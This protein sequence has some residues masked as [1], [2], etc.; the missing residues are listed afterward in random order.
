MLVIRP[1]YYSKSK[2][3]K[4]KRKLHPIPIF[5]FMLH[6]YNKKVLTKRAKIK[7]MRKKKRK[8]K[9]QRVPFK[10]W[11][12]W[13]NIK[14]LN[15]RLFSNF[16]SKQ[17]KIAIPLI[18]KKNSSRKYYKNVVFLTN[19]YIN[20]GYDY[21]VSSSRYWFKIPKASIYNHFIITYIPINKIKF[22]SIKKS[23]ILKQFQHQNLQYA[24]NRLLRKRLRRWTNRYRK[25]KK[26]AAYNSIVLRLFSILTGLSL[27]HI[28]K[29]WLITRRS[30]LNS[31]GINQLINN[32]TIQ[33]TL[34][35]HN[36][37]FLLRL[38]PSTISGLLLLKQGAIICNGQIHTGSTALQPGDILQLQPN[39]LQSNKF[40]H[41]VT[42]KYS[43]VAYL[44]FIYFDFSLL[45]IMILR[46]PFSY[47]LL[48]HSFLSTRWVR[49]Y[50]RGF[51]IKNKHY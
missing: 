4:R 14:K 36:L 48:F 34:L 32:F 38:I 35:P 28:K 15:Y 50:I 37:L 3:I 27:V 33:I 1:K 31:W 7:L 29:L 9:T 20:S 5:G 17:R 11:R 49:Y 47:E 39:T 19:L 26:H 46:Y 8:F 16:I 24:K 30:N 23:I 6:R 51:S 22:F 25:I 44:P 41:S 12:I 45:L 43:K 10:V 18:K 40:M 2:T 21:A 13:S 42:R